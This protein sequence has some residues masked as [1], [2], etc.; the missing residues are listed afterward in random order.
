MQ[1]IYIDITSL[2][3]VKFVTGIQRVV[4]NV[5]LEMYKVIP[6]RLVLLN[7]DRNENCYQVIETLKFVE[8]SNGELLDLEKVLKDS[9]D[10]K[11][12]EQMRGDI[13]FDIDSVWNS[14][15]R[16]SVLLPILK[17]YGVKLAVY[18]YDV[19]PI[20]D[21][22]YCHEDTVFNFLNYLG[23]YLQYADLIIASAQSTVNEIYTLMDYLNL[24]HIP[25]YVSWLGSDFKREDKKQ[26]VIEDKV[27]K[28][29][30]REFVLAVGTIEPRKNHSFLLDAFDQGLYSDN[31]NLVL[32]G[33]EGW[34][35]DALMKRIKSH[36]LY[37]KQLFYFN[38][39]DDDNVDYLYKKAFVIGFPTFNEGFGLP[40]VE[41]L[42]RGTP[43][44]A[45][46]RDVLR[47]VGRDY[48][49]YFDPFCPDQFI[50]KVRSYLSN[51]MEY[52]EWKKNIKDFV[53]F[54]WRETTER[55]MN[56]LDVL[57]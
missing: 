33:R 10:F 41:A 28:A 12:S 42:E 56:A 53:P 17:G 26:A 46:D 18:I 23:A 3:Q 25:A 48:C 51:K 49:E 47:E 52:V 19:I 7:Y 8:Y 5:V 39:L 37:E 22:K 4:K 13:F 45:T 31:L 54:T 11:L 57:A 29:S 1:K 38:D 20:T 16:R 14:Q 35:V 21:A 15:Y 50:A 9:S 27:I 44:M 40:I 34:N 55:I 30:E 43:V 36:P 24:E 2:L 32:V 6:D